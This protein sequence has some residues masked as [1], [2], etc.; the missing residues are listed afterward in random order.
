MIKN[1]T[2]NNLLH[3]DNENLTLENIDSTF[4]IELILIK[5]KYIKLSTDNPSTR[6]Y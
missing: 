5:L 4:I 6:T 2:T 3:N 1:L